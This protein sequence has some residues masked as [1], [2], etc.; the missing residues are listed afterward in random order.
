[1]CKISIKHLLGT[2]FCCFCAPLGA[3]KQDH[4]TQPERRISRPI[5][6]SSA[7]FQLYQGYIL[8]HQIPRNLHD[9]TPRLQLSIYRH[10]DQEH[11]TSGPPS[12]LPP[13]PSTYTEGLPRSLFSAYAN[14]G[15]QFV[16]DFFSN[17][18]DL[19]VCNLGTDIILESNIAHAT[20]VLGVNAR[21]HLEK[22]MIQINVQAE[23]AILRQPYELPSVDAANMVRGWFSA[24]LE[25]NPINSNLLIPPSLSNTFKHAKADL[26]KLYF[27]HKALYF[28]AALKRLP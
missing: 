5:P 21:T 23:R 11:Q 17:C 19:L 2:L 1:M 24:P 22:L 13:L 7:E 16:D 26:Y 14:E 4:P 28:Q 10:I 3:F 9:L 12:F 27:M 20:E 15:A 6:L 18:R 25:N 8:Q